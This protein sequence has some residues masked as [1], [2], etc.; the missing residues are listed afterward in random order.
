LTTKLD[1]IQS[2]LIPKGPYVPRVTKPV[3]VSVAWPHTI[4][5]FFETFC[6]DASRSELCV[7]TNF[8]I[9]GPMD[10][11]LWVF[12]VF[13]QGLARAGMCW[14][15]PTRVDYLH[16]KWRAGKK[17]DS[18]K[19]WADWPYPGVDPWPAGDRRPQVN[20]WIVLYCWIFFYFLKHFL[21]LAPTFGS[22]KCSIPHG[23][24]WF[25]FKNK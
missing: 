21:K 9:F 13:G 6:E 3:L 25:H 5:K 22:V 10:Q 4:F 8:I 11:K 7:S 12:E 19:K 20:T 2:K 24:W 17:K 23:D 14:S 15:Q 16:K 18:T 1:L